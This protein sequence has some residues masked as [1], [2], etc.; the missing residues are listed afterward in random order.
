MLKYRCADVKAWG[1]S[2]LSAAPSF[3]PPPE[4]GSLYPPHPYYQSFSVISLQL[5][6]TFIRLSMVTSILKHPFRT[7]KHHSC[8]GFL[9]SAF[10][11]VLNI[12]F[13]SS[14][15]SHSKCPSEVNLD[16]FFS[17]YLPPSIF[18]FILH[19]SY[20]RATLKCNSFI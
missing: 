6:A 16:Q 1:W 11:C 4:L 19:N 3:S 10:L 20:T 9:L 8:P 2:P 18:T 13:L 14:P 7:F 5:L 17:Q 15:R 12:P